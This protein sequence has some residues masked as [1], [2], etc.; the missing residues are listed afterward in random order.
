MTISKNDYV[1]PS[2]QTPK[3][4]LLTKNKSFYHDYCN[5]KHRHRFCCY[6]FGQLAITLIALLVFS[7]CSSS[8]Y[9]STSEGLPSSIELP[10]GS[11]ETTARSSEGFQ[12]QSLLE[13]KIEIQIGAF[14][15]SRIDSSQD[16]DEDEVEQYRSSGPANA[17][18][19]LQKVGSKAPIHTAALNIHGYYKG[20]IMIPGHQRGNDYNLGIH[21]PGYHTRTILIR[22]LLQYSRIHFGTSIASTEH[23]VLG[24]SHTIIGKSVRAAA[25]SGQ[26]QDMNGPAS[27]SDTLDSDGDLI[28]NSY[29]AFP[30]D[31]RR[32]FRT[33][34]PEDDFLTV[35]YEDNYP[36]TGDKDYNDFAVRY[37]V[38][39]IRNADNQ[40]VEILGIVEPVALVAAYNHRFG[41]YIRFTQN[42]GT[43]RI[44]NT[45][46]NGNV[47]KR[48]EK[49]V[50]NAADV[51]VYEST[52]DSI[53]FVLP[54][55]APQTKKVYRYNYSY[56][57][58]PNF[59][60]AQMNGHRAYFNIRFDVPIEPENIDQAPYDPYLMVKPN[61]KGYDVHL[62]GKS[63]LPNS[64]NPSSAPTDFRNRSGLPWALLV[65][66]NWLPSKEKQS[67][68]IAYPNFSLWY[69]SRG[70]TNTDW[71]LQ[72]IAGQVEKPNL[73]ITEGPSF[74]E[75]DPTAS[76]YLNRMDWSVSAGASINGCTA[77]QIVTGEVSQ[78]LDAEAWQ[79]FLLCY[80]GSSSNPFYASETS[81]FNHTSLTEKQGAVAYIHLLHERFSLSQ[82]A[83]SLSPLQKLQRL[84]QA[85]TF[86]MPRSSDTTKLI[87][88]LENLSYDEV[89]LSFLSHWFAS[90]SYT[91]TYDYG[92]NPYVGKTWIEISGTVQDHTASAISGASITIQTGDTDII[93][94]QLTS[95]SDG[96]YM[97]SLELAN[98]LFSWEINLNLSVPGYMKKSYSL[99]LE[100]KR[101]N[102]RYN[103]HTVPLGTA[104]PAQGGEIHSSSTIV[105]A[106]VPAG[107]IGEASSFSI[108]SPEEYVMTEADPDG[109]QEEQKAI[110]FTISPDQ[111][112]TKPVMLEVQLSAAFKEALQ[113]QEGDEDLA[114]FVEE[115]GKLRMLTPS[116]YDPQT[117]TLSAP[118]SHFSTFII[119]SCV[120]TFCRAGGNGIRLTPSARASIL[121]DLRYL[122]FPSELPEFKADLVE[123]LSS[124]GWEDSSTSV[125]EDLNIA[126]ICNG[127]STNCPEYIV[128][129]LKDGSTNIPIFEGLDI[130]ESF[131]LGDAFREL[132]GDLGHFLGN[133]F[134]GILNI[135]GI[136]V[137]GGQTTLQSAILKVN[138]DLV[139]Q[140]E[141]CAVNPLSSHPQPRLHSIPAIRTS[142]STTIHIGS[143]TGTWRVPGI[144]RG[145]RH[146]SWFH[147][148]CIKK[149]RRHIP[150]DTVTVHMN[151]MRFGMSHGTSSCDRVFADDGVTWCLTQV[152]KGR[153]SVS[154]STGSFRDKYPEILGRVEKNVSGRV[155][156]AIQ[157][158]VFNQVRERFPVS[159]FFDDDNC[160]TPTQSY[161][162]GGT[163]NGLEDGESL[164]LQ[165]NGIDDLDI[166]ANGA[167]T[168]PLNLGAGANYSVR[169]KEGTLG[170]GRNCE[171][172]QGDGLL[173]TGD[174]LLT[175]EDVSSVA[176]ICSDTVVFPQAGSSRTCAVVN[177][178]AKC[179]G[180][181]RNGE[182]GNASTTNSSVPAQVSGLTNGVTGISLGVY[183]T[184][185]IHNGAAKCWGH[186]NHRYGRQLGNAMVTNSSIPVQVT[187]L[188]SGVTDISI[189]NIHTCAIHN[190]AAKCWGNNDYG[191]LGNGS[192]TNSSVPV[193]VTGLT[194]GVTDIASGGGHTCAI[195]NGAVKCWG[196]NYYGQ[197]GNGTATDPTTLYINA[198]LDYN[199]LNKNTAR[200]SSVPVQVFGLTSGVTDISLGR[201]HTC[202]IHNG[203]IKCWGAD[204]AGQLGGEPGVHHDYYSLSSNFF[205]YRI[206]Q[207]YSTI[208]IVASSLPTG[209]ATDISSVKFHQFPY[210]AQLTNASIIDGSI[211]LW[212]RLSS[213]IRSNNL[214]NY[215]LFTLT[216]LD[217]IYEEVPG[218]SQP[219][220]GISIGRSH[221]CTVA[222]NQLY[223]WGRNDYGQLGLGHANHTTAPTLPIDFSASFGASGASGAS[224]QYG[225]PEPM[226]IILAD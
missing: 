114:L 18:L 156:D 222:N 103:F 145:K 143:V 180:Y 207:S 13:L 67:I 199:S 191:Q 57:T 152:S 20:R 117:S 68:E 196:H 3:T 185:A 95:E 147:Y 168:F 163:V 165:N 74:P 17:V 79:D 182:L 208:P 223:C 45:D 9:K 5:F 176:I 47:V 54:D 40:I 65:P 58:N 204:Y 137:Q 4:P 104:D 56:L 115:D 12:F 76:N 226:R 154:G 188:T 151:N 42:Q 187:G 77:P 158:E 11:L 97:T 124:K 119:S 30:N 71:Y 53:S 111:K 206:T 218:L 28:P 36:G 112:F 122:N 83:A 50:R 120:A 215:G 131:D 159:T 15:L 144:C 31:P 214:L 89:V 85:I 197:L 125:E 193:Q 93:L 55:S 148:P 220:T 195:H 132:G 33:V 73:V 203:A 166:T 92:Q 177:E 91:S 61:N 213:N 210:L 70:Q 72:P 110:R 84:Y 62:A 139:V 224:G 174:S 8:R 6:L 39:E 69:Q 23:S 22:D 153:S 81:R 82:A 1:P 201:Q 86:R 149:Q 80:F 35:A 212:S 116:I 105:K 189:G 37:Q 19:T 43:L 136:D 41:I 142:V 38:A 175:I 183:H 130:S 113:V 184:C 217:P 100:A 2:M 10:S 24:S 123:E 96:S 27:T 138:S 48:R 59:S 108:T 170:Q 173:S 127:S 118:T 88:A 162:I 140:A 134:S 211:V 157:G 194:S 44:E 60:E 181:N 169:I 198:A 46:H 128:I 141:Q 164:I 146:F 190:G 21:K 7:A 75:I 66:A 106:Y 101:T 51:V 25:V 178:S 219:I 205:R 221:T 29:D 98:N 192:T 32:A 150:A 109:G 94:K 34:L 155:F 49:Q 52:R 135:G 63:A 87:T 16:L 121:G 126:D 133:V 14:D 78:V 186:D 90:A 64:R 102:Y 26:Q 161:S 225:P 216:V 171:V 99:L 172:N 167:F 107:A 179:W 129:N 160:V 202:A 209:T 200:K